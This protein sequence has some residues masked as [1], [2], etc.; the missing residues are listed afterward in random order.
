MN[1]LTKTPEA[2]RANALKTSVPRRTPPSRKTGI[3][4]S[5]A[6]TTCD[7]NLTG[8]KLKPLFITVF[9]VNQNREINLFER[10]YSCRDIIELASS[11]VRHYNPCSSIFSRDSC[12]KN[13][14]MIK[15]IFLTFR[16]F[17]VKGLMQIITI[18]SCNNTL[19]KNWQACDRLEP[20]YILEEEK[21]T[22][23][24]NEIITFLNLGGGNKSYYRF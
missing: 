12:C 20:F 6:L 22:A 17:K 16:N 1:G 24:R 7:L 11:V 19:D 5:T 9:Y 3:R 15:G 4:P 23:K 8:R 18:L 13:F 21:Q 2:P 14:L 10:H